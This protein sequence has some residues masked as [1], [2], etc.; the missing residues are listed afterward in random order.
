MTGS[1]LDDR[2]VEALLRGAGPDRAL[3][4]VLDGLRDAGRGPAPAPSAR[5]AALLATGLPAAAPA[6]LSASA[7]ATAPAT[8][9]ERP[10]TPAAADPA[11]ALLAALPPAELARRTRV[12]RTVLA[13]VLAG[14]VT[15]GLTGVAAAHDALPDPAQT[16]V[17]S[18]MNTLTPFHVDLP[19]GHDKHDLRPD[20]AAPAPAPG[21]RFAPTLAARDPRPAG[22]ARPATRPAAPAARAAHRPAGQ[23]ADA[24]GTALAERLTGRPV[25]AGPVLHGGGAGGAS[26]HAAGH[27]TKHR[28]HHG[29][30]GGTGTRAHRHGHHGR[31]H[32]RTGRS[33][34]TPVVG[35]GA[36]QPV[37]TPPAA[38]RHRAQ[39]ARGTPAR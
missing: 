12:G 5:L 10:A 32:A 13:G 20:G 26:G 11:A 18:V 38:G 39:P 8:S 30:H 34:T 27:G 33:G 25:P 14:G 9:T 1:P 23:H 16:V 21:R 28:K 2:A 15:L 37:A 3:C 36:E 29:R 7:P 35:L 22:P 17:R 19:A 6:A 24:H 31:H 4:A